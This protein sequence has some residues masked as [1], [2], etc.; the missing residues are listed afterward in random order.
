ML[1]IRIALGI[2]LAAAAAIAVV[3]SLVLFDLV[4]GGTG[5]GLCATGLA[6]CDPG[7]FAG[8]ELFAILSIALFIVLGT[9]AMLLK[10]LHHLEDRQDGRRRGGA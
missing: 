7:Y 10:V 4:N 5:F 2:L 6:G 9:A 8:P 3:P 1:A